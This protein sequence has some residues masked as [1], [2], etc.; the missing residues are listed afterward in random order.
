MPDTDTFAEDQRHLFRQVYH[1]VID[2]WA[3]PLDRPEFERYRPIA[4]RIDASVHSFLVQLR[5][6]GGIDPHRIAPKANPGLDFFNIDWSLEHAYPL[7][8]KDRQHLPTEVV[9]FLERVESASAV[10]KLAAA[11]RTHTDV[12]A[13]FYRDVFGVI[14]ADHVLVPLEFDDQGEPDGE[15]TDIAPGLVAGWDAFLTLTTGGGGSP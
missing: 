6:D 7:S 14:E 3:G 9:T 15:R 1:G 13:G 11:D 5:G 8:G 2:G 4:A 12:L 10:A